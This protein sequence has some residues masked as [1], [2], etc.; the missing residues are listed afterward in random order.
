MTS[1]NTT[2]TPC[3]SL[4]NSNLSPELLAEVLAKENGDMLLLSLLAKEES[5]QKS[6]TICLSKGSPI[7][8][9]KHPDNLYPKKGK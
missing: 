5:R 4:T 1:E 6:H 8:L 7:G 2:D 3:K 9:Y